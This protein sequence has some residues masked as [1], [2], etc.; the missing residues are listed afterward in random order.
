[1]KR[2]IWLAFSIAV[3][4]AAGVTLV[5]PPKTSQWTTSS[6]QAFAEYEAGQ[7]D[8]NKFYFPE[9]LQHFER[10]NEFDPDFL[11]AKWRVTQLL[12]REGSDQADRFIDELMTVDL[13]KLTPREEF[14]STTGAPYKTTNPTRPPVY[15]TSASKSTPTTPT[16]WA[17]SG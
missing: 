8:M 7:A 3:L 2:W 1:M 6:P 12:M 16:C 15:S 11:L 5:A 17:T 10:T 9:A 13:S 14:L 4:A